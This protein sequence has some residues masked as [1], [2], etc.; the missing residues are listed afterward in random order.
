MW[1]CLFAATQQHDQELGHLQMEAIYAIL[2]MQST[3]ACI[4]NTACNKIF[5]ALTDLLRGVAI[6]CLPVSTVQ[7]CTACMSVIAGWRYFAK[8]QPEVRGQAH[9]SWVLLTC[10]VALL[11]VIACTYMSSLSS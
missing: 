5:V 6:S 11:E 8:R 2:Y 1:L 4:S 7:Y 3:R 10:M 9:P